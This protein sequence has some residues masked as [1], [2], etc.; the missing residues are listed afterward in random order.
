MENTETQDDRYGRLRKEL[1]QPSSYSEWRH[2]N[3]VYANAPFAAAVDSNKVPAKSN[4]ML[5]EP[6]ETREPAMSD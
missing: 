1:T 5:A 3:I 2:A 4:R 6:T